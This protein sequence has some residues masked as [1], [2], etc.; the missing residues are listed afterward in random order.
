M[1]RALT[2]K[3]KKETPLFDEMRARMSCHK[4]TAQKRKNATG[5]VDADNLNSDSPVIRQGIGSM[6]PQPQK[7]KRTEESLFELVLSDLLLLQKDLLLATPIGG[8]LI[9]QTDLDYLGDCT[10]LA[11]YEEYC[12]CNMHVIL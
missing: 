5:S 2:A 1:T 8:A 7:R 3:V 12:G 10:F 6:T 9:T 11:L 4:S